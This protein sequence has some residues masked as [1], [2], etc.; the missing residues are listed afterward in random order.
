MSEI[1]NVKVLSDNNSEIS[2]IHDTDMTLMS[3]LLKENLISGAFCGG[4]GSCGRCRVQY[5]NG[6]PLP[7][8]SDRNTFTPD[9]LLK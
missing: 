4:M 9:E 8:A 5:I 2:I 6:T 3:T 1:I 7:T